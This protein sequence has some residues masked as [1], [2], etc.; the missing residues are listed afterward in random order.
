MA[1]KNGER[2][3][4][5]ANAISEII[6]S[7]TR[8]NSSFI[9]LGDM[10]DTPGSEFLEE[11]TLDAELSFTNALANMIEVGE[12]NHTKYPPDNH[13]WTH[14]FNPQSGVYHYNLYDQIWISNALTDNLSGAWVARRERVG[15]DGSDHDPV[16]IELEI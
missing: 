10:N 5:Q 14:R 3:R 15:G 9:L 2:R 7:V 11:F 4:K 8:P 1:A 6:K 16:W 13:F 12:M